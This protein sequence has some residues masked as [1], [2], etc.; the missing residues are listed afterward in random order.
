MGVRIGGEEVELLPERALWWPA[1]RTLAVA[2]LHW[3]KEETFHAFGIP[4]PGGVLADD[5]SRLGAAVERTRPARLLVLGDMVH[6]R[7]HPGAIGEVGAWRA[8][9]FHG[10]S[11]EE[12]FEVISDVPSLDPGSR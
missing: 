12:L 9:E 2:D 11:N 4:V 7:L 1:T 8:V 3:G 5:L 6:G 10:Y